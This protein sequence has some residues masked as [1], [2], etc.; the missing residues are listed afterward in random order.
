MLKGSCPYLYVW[1]GE[2]Y[3]F[4]TDLLGAAPLG[5]Q[6]ADGVIASDNPR[7]IVKIDSDLMAEQDGEY[8]FQFTEELW[9]TIYLDEVGL[10]VVDHPEGVEAFTDERFVPPPYSDPEV[11]TTRGRRYPMTALNTNGEDVAERLSAYDYRYP[12]VLKPTRDSSNRIR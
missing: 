11:V 5:L 2:R 6:L 9:E 1:D 4:V 3:R 12:N 7:E 8:V 10:W